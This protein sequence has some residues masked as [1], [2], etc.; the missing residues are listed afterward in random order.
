MTVRDR[1]ALAGIVLG[2]LLAG[3]GLPPLWATPAPGPTCTELCV[4]ETLV[5]S[6]AVGGN[7]LLY[8]AGSCDRCDG[9]GTANCNTVFP[10]GTCAPSP[11]DETVVKRIA[12]CY[13]ICT[14]DMA[15]GGKYDYVSGTS[16]TDLGTP[17][18]AE[19]RWRCL[20]GS[21]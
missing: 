12:V 3:S 9:G 16:A 7:C 18:P 19:P 13:G 8:N 4:E 11:R 20:V 6:C 14:C 1:F 5:K 15:G 17:M 2:T 10:T 21:S